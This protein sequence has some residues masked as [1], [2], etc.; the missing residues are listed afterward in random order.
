M[1]DEL[2]VFNQLCL[3]SSLFVLSGIK[4]KQTG[5][6]QDLRL[7]IGENFP[8]LIMGD[9]DIAFQAYIRCLAGKFGRI[10]ADKRLALN[11]PCLNAMFGKFIGGANPGHSPA[12]N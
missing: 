10:T 9:T 7:F 2:G 8:E 6:C 5:I 1:I 4:S 11:Q 12:D 3:I